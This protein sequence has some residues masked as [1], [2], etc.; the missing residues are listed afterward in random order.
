MSEGEQVEQTS[1]DNHN[2]SSAETQ[3][4][5]TK[6]SAETTGKE[7]P[8]NGYDR[9]E[10]D[11][12]QVEARFK[13]MYGQVKAQDRKIA[14]RDNLLREQAEAIE[15]LTKATGQVVEHIQAK[16][17]ESLEKTLEA[18]ADSAFEKGDAAGYKKAV[19]KLAKA[20]AERTVKEIMG[21]QQPAK[22]AAVIQQPRN[23]SEIAQ[24][25]HSDGGLDNHGVSIVNAWQSEKDES[26]NLLRPWAFDGDE[27]Y[28]DAIAEA[29][30]IF[31]SRRYA[32][33]TMEQKLAEVDKRMGF[34]R[35]ESQQ[36]VMGSNLTSN[37]KTNN[38][39]IS[40]DM[41][42]VMKRLGPGAK[43]KKGEDPLQ[44][45]RQQVAKVNSQQ[46]GG[47]R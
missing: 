31:T 28:V 19:T 39:K 1:V 22:Q 23:A 12:P 11:D 43:A 16:D 36:N 34:V 40:P 25:A 32:G 5:E 27:S 6:T 29:N 3:T 41:E 47:R 8:I 45:Y 17:S 37:R 44:W 30:A 18:E 9:V 15:R 2:A 4:N 46:Q 35:R 24:R 21:K 14:E 20:Q 7:K 10:F 33:H 13:R 42:K 26:G 38:I